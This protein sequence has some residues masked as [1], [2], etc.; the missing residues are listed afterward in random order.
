MSALSLDLPSTASGSVAAPS[1]P[2]DPL[3]TKLALAK[4]F[5]A[6]GDNDGARA[7]VEEVIAA[8]QGDLKVKAQQLLAEL[9]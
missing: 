6:I 1:M 4:E 9:A 3:A 2:E 7:L 8:S 5:S